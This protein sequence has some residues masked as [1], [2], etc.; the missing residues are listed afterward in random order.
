MPIKTMNNNGLQVL[1]E[2]PGEY[3]IYID[4]DAVFTTVQRYVPGTYQEFSDRK[5]LIDSSAGLMKSYS[6]TWSTQDSVNLINEINN[7]ALKRLE[8]QPM[9]LPVEG[10]ETPNEIQVLSARAVPITYECCFRVGNEGVYVGEGYENLANDRTT[11]WKTSA[12]I[13]GSGLYII[14]TDNPIESV[15][16]F[17]K[18]GVSVPNEKY[19][20]NWEV[21]KGEGFQIKQSNRCVGGD[22]V[23]SVEKS[24]TYTITTDQ[25]ATSVSDLSYVRLTTTNS[26]TIKLQITKTPTP[27]PFVKSVM[28]SGKL[29]RISNANETTH[30]FLNKGDGVVTFGN[31]YFS[32]K[33]E[34]IQ[35]LLV[36]KALLTEQE[37]QTELAKDI[38]LR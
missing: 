4:K 31:G 27:K 32:L 23:I 5:S 36:Y 20:F 13:L 30:T 18:S 26:I 2:V 6:I 37:K 7:K 28:P 11:G 35:Q 19:S 15:Y 21:A 29:D 33:G 14:N 10:E 1:E 25:N 12:T 16:P 3:A 9:M 38:K 8:E 24:G 22:K 34:N 17:N